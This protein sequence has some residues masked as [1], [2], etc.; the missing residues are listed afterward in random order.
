MEKLNKI[1]EEGLYSV[2]IE[3]FPTTFVVLVIA[4]VIFSICLVKFGR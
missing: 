3:Y 1:I 4:I 2:F